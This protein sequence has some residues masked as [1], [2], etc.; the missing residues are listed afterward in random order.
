MKDGYYSRKYSTDKE[1]SFEWSHHRFLS[2][3]LKVTTIVTDGFIS[4]QINWKCWLLRKGEN[5]GTVVPRE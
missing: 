3:D 4:N 1:V 5:Q 2:K